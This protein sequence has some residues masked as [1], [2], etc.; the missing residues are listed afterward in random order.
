MLTDHYYAF[1]RLDFF[2]ETTFLYMVENNL[3]FEH[4]WVYNHVRVAE[5][6]ENAVVLKEKAGQVGF[7]TDHKIKQLRAIE[8]QLAFEADRVAIC[9]DVISVNTDPKRCAE[10]VTET[11]IK[12]AENLREYQFVTMKGA[13][14]HITA[15]FNS[16]GKR[17]HDRSDDGIQAFLLAVKAILDFLARELEPTQ[18]ELIDQMRARRTQVEPKRLRMGFY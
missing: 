2:K 3:G 13:T 6:F 1:R 7:H 10:A 8:M 9:K 18:Y 15:L 11:L 17:L 14:T 12:Q 16:E 5:K 4:Q